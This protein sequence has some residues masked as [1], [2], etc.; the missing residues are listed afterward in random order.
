MEGEVVGIRRGGIQPE[1]RTGA[2]VARRLLFE[3]QME[4]IAS[5]LASL[6]RGKETIFLRL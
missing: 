4:L 1:A 6:G 5:V 3:A 2:S